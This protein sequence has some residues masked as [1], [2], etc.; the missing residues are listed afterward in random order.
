MQIL[1]PASRFEEKNKMRKIIL[2][3]SVYCSIILF[4][5]ALMAFSHRKTLLPDLKIKASHFRLDSANKRIYFKAEL[6]NA[7]DVVFKIIPPHIFVRTYIS[8]NK[9]L[10]GELYTGTIPINE[11]IEL[12]P[13]D[14]LTLSRE[15]YIQYQSLAQLKTYPYCVIEVYTPQNMESNVSNNKSIYKHNLPR[16]TGKN[17]VNDIPAGSPA[18][19]SKNKDNSGA[20]SK[21]SVP[22]STTQPVEGTTIE[23]GRIIIKPGYRAILNYDKQTVTIVQL[24]DSETITTGHYRCICYYVDGECYIQFAT[25]SFTCA[26]SNEKPCRDDCELVEQNSDPASKPSLEKP[27]KK[28]VEQKSKN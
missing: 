8:R 12:K 19:E 17:L 22:D 26:S 28:L 18:G 15:Y 7:G 25:G 10:G 20:G 13:G 27:W 11:I 9:L 24:R 4:L 21:P 16:L 1:P 3:A 23:N 2:L 14:S 5:S 6:L